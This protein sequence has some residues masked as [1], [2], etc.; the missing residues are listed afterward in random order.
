MARYAE[1][2]GEKFFEIRAISE[3]KNGKAKVL[4]M[5]EEKARAQVLESSTIAQAYQ[6]NGDSIV[7]YI[8]IE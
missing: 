4:D 7:R 2:H 8:D 3:E 1:K 5:T 6:D